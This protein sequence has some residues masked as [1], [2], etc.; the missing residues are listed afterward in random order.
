YL[1]SSRQHW[2]LALLFSLMVC[3]QFIERLLVCGG[4]AYRSSRLASAKVR[5]LSDMTKLFGEK[6][7]RN[8]HLRW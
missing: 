2:R 4:V 3:N 1:L 8:F 5:R 6:F 7:L